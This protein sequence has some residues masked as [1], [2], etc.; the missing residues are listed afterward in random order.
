MRL[1]FRV[2]SDK[3]D[4]RALNHP[5]TPGLSQDLVSA[6]IQAAHRISD[7]W[8][9]QLIKQDHALEWTSDQ[10][11]RPAVYS[12]VPS[13]PYGQPT[14][15]AVANPVQFSD[16]NLDSAARA[17]VANALQLATPYTVVEYRN[18]P[19]T[20]EITSIIGVTASDTPT[21]VNFHTSYAEDD[22]EIHLHPL[23]RPMKSITANLALKP[24]D[25]S[26]ESYP[27]L[28]IQ[29]RSTSRRS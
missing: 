8:I 1:E 27:E 18:S 19:Y 3:T 20:L 4:R 28:E 5:N 16:Y 9:E 2:I 12:N 11:E 22:P 15:T 14:H 24:R 26:R 21:L 25:H 13:E 10:N 7:R 23:V 6:A 29:Y 17:A